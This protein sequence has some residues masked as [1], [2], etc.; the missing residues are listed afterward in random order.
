MSCTPVRAAMATL[1]ALRAWTVMMAPYLAASS[2]AALS[3]SSFMYVSSDGNSGM[4]P[5]PEM[6]SLTARTPASHWRATTSRIWRGVR[7]DVH[8]PAVGPEGSGLGDHGAARH[9]ARAGHQ[10]AVDEVLDQDV[11]FGLEDAG[12]DDEGVPALEERPG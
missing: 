7:D 1:R 2:T 4:I 3:I 12:P 10:P 8:Q 5:S 9:D 6:N 11:V